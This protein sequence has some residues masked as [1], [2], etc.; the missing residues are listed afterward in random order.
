MNYTVNSVIGCVALFLGLLLMLVMIDA[1]SRDSVPYWNSRP[2]AGGAASPV[3]ASPAPARA[4]G[5]VAH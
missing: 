2:P 5:G 4:P 1:G 3:P